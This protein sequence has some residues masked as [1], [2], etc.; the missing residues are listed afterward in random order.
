MLFGIRSADSNFEDLPDSD[1]QS[2]FVAED[3]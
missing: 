2:S 1:I 3:P